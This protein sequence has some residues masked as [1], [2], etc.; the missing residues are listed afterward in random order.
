MKSQDNIQELLQKQSSQKSPPKK[1]ESKGRVVFKN[2]SNLTE[3]SAGKTSAISISK[4]DEPD[5]ESVGSGDAY[6]PPSTS[7]QDVT[8]DKRNDF[9]RAMVHAVEADRENAKQE[10]KLISQKTK[11]RNMSNMR[12]NE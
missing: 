7:L 4:F 8:S 2:S 10:A 3:G 11:L 5:E 9:E 12:V 1:S 6:V